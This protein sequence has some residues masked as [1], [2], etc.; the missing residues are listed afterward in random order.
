MYSYT[1]QCSLI[2][3]K[4]LRQPHGCDAVLGEDDGKGGGDG[5]RWVAWGGGGGV[6][7]VWHM[8]V[9]ASSTEWVQRCGT[10]LH[11]GCLRRA[12]QVVKFTAGIDKLVQLQ[13]ADSSLF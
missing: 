13:L 5:T 2:P 12:G 11:T 8:V 7:P 1:L 3:G 6:K 4:T 9:A 10:I